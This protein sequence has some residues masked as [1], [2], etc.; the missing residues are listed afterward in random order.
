MHTDTSVDGRHA[1]LSRAL[2]RQVPFDE[3][4]AIERQFGLGLIGLMV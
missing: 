1:Q 2:Y 4:E 3:D